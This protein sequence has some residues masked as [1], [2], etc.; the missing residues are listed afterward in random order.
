VARPPG[1]DVAPVRDERLERL[2]QVEDRGPSL[3]DGEV[4]DAEGRLKVGL[5]VELID[6]DLRDDVLLQLDDQMTPKDV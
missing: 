6:D 3:R 5:P 2:L 1:D 4:D